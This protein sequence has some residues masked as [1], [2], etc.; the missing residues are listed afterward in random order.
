[1]SE[2]TPV[3]LVPFKTYVNRA[4]PDVPVLVIV[5]ADTRVKLLPLVAVPPGVVTA[6]VPVVVP[7]ATVAV[8]CVALLTVKLA[9]LV[10]LN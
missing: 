9:A 10:P 7:L 6:I 3:K 8:I 4:N 2:L 1:M 5:G